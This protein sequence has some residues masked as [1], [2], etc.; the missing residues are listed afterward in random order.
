MIYEKG[1]ALVME[2]S[3]GCGMNCVGCQINKDL[4]ATLDLEHLTK[5]QSICLDLVDMGVPLVEYELG[6][7]DLVKASNRD[8]IF[9]NEI[10]QNTSALFDTL[11]LNVSMS[12]ADEALYTALAEQ[13]NDFCKSKSVAL[14]IPVNLV[15]ICNE[16]YFE[17]VMNNIAVFKDSLRLP[18]S[19]IIFTVII[20]DMLA[21]KRQSDID[22]ESLFKRCKQLRK[23]GYGFDFLSHH[24]LG[25]LSSEEVRNDFI[26]TLQKVNTAFVKFMSE[27]DLASDRR[28]TS[29]LT[30]ME[31]LEVVSH[32]SQLYLRPTVREKSN[33]FHSKLA[34]DVDSGQ[35]L[36]LRANELHAQSVH[37][38]LNYEVCQSCS[39][40]QDCSVRMV[41]HVMDILQTEQ[42]II[43]LREVPLN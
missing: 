11:A 31:S 22:Y 21:L 40:Q 28:Y 30:H 42:C 35:Q 43:G 17:N 1:V 20:D 39:R 19:E 9:S 38:G 33:L 29:L 7:T 24:G 41:H 15:H 14:Q 10:I 34:L 13:V 18:V 4:P 8:E 3:R 27:D 16:R 2:L 37:L 23:L 5:V 12:Y 26:K 6:P 36:M 25:D 32:K